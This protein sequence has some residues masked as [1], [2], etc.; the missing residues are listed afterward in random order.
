MAGQFPF[1]EQI[2]IAW[3]LLG[4]NNGSSMLMACLRINYRGSYAARKIAA[5]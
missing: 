5:Y 1:D 3:P 2:H 4:L